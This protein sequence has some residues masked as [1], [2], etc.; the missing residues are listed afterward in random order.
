MVHAVLHL[1]VKD[2]PSKLIKV[3]R[4]SPTAAMFYFLFPRGWARIRIPPN[5]DIARIR[6]ALKGISSF[7]QNICDRLDFYLFYLY[8]FFFFFFFCC[9]IAGGWPF[10]FA[11]KSQTIYLSTFS[12]KLVINVNSNQNIKCNACMCIVCL[13]VLRGSFN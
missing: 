4:S 5:E 2:S 12:A 6:M 1:K 8:N 11:P 13:Q 3:D 9:M 10:L 7:F